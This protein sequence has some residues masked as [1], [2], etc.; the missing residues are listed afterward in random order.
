MAVCMIIPYNN[1]RYVDEKIHETFL[2]SF[3]QTYRQDID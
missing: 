2:S 1:Y 3:F